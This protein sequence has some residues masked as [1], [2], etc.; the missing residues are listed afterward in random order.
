MF[1]LVNP[2]FA[3]LYRPN[4]GLS[5]LKAKLLRDGHRS[6]IFYADHLLAAHFKIDDYDWVHT[7]YEA[8]TG[9]W[10]FSGFVRAG[11]NWDEGYPELMLRRGTYTA[12]QIERL[13]RALEPLARYLDQVV[14]EILARQPEVVGC[15]STFQ[16]NNAALAILK[17]VK[18]RAPN[19]VTVIGGANLEGELG[20][21]VAR[22]PWVDYVVSGEADGCI[23][24]LYE[25]CSRYGS[26]IPEVELPEE[27]ATSTRKSGR[28]KVSDMDDLPYPDFDDFFAS[29]ERFP[30][31]T[32][33]KPELALEG[34]RGC[35]WGQVKH[36]TFCGLNGSGMAYR[37]KSARRLLD[38]IQTLSAKYSISLI[39]MV[40]NI[41]APKHLKD[42]LPALVG[43][44]LRFF[45][46]VK[47]NLKGAHFELL[48]AAGVHWVQPGIESFSENVL[49]LMRKGQRP[50]QNIFV[51]KAARENGI[52]LSWNLLMRHPGETIE[53]IVEQR[54][55]AHSLMH[56]QPPQ[57]C[58]EVRPDRFS[59]LFAESEGLEPFEV[60]SYIYEMDRGEIR[61]IAYLFTLGP[62]PRPPAYTE[63]YA[64]RIEALVNKVE[65]WRAA[66]QVPERRSL[67]FENGG[68]RD[69]R[70]PGKDLVHQ[71]S[72]VETGILQHS[73]Q[74]TRISEV[75]SAVGEG[76][77]EG[78]RRLTELRLCYRDES[79]V[80]SLVL[81]KPSDLLPSLIG[82]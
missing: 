31:L 77:D 59:P 22:F 28:G 49:T 44:H 24:R 75:A 63:R 32:Q 19:V 66:W 41:I 13:R 7:D 43:S 78:L 81:N 62:D 18:R 23:S 47:A 12:G 6:Q 52:R 74:P 50:I 38:E 48:R 33:V 21:P 72:A 60:Y 26:A 46:E 37:S 79:H 1:L 35:W 5:L 42:L 45:W 55:L 14:D 10:L 71:L 16:Q 67:H 20:E 69:R 4:L 80:L 76:L 73:S 54:D 58:C 3:S 68:V 36:C 51:L 29:L 39:Q 61:K 2:P 64:T 11:G 82:D 8:L 34:S 40:D 30:E 15:S 70:W 9:E 27:V 25:L 65:A 53:D 56:L 57:A 17:E